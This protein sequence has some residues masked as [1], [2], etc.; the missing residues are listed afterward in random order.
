MRRLMVVLCLLTYRAQAAAQEFPP[1]TEEGKKA[2]TELL[3][4]FDKAGAIK[5]VKEPRTGVQQI[6]VADE[7]KLK[8]TARE[9]RTKFTSSV[10]DALLQLYGH[11]GVVALLLRLGEE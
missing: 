6:V 5:R 3:I 9:H 4:A 10:R 11:P 2:A 1:V 8:E 7:T